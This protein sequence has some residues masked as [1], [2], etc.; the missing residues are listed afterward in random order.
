[1]PVK[2]AGVFKCAAG[3]TTYYEVE[4]EHRAKS[5][6]EHAARVNYTFD[7][8]G[9][10]RP[11]RA[12]SEPTWRAKNLD[13][14]GGIDKFYVLRQRPQQ[15]PKPG[16]AYL[17]RQGSFSVTLIFDEMSR[18]ASASFEG[19]EV[20]YVRYYAVGSDSGALLAVAYTIGGEAH[21]LVL[22]EFDGE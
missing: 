10:S 9:R 12:E 6:F 19:D 11:L 13:E 5:T 15:L 4:L 7:D 21:F 16:S 17:G 20:Q 3:E 2:E 8:Q 22:M 1:M 14:I 18:V